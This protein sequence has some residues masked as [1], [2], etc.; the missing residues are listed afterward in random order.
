MIGAQDDGRHR[1]GTMMIHGLWAKLRGRRPWHAGGRFRLGWFST[2]N[3]K[4]GIAE[5]SKFLLDA[6]DRRRFDWTVLGSQN[7]AL[8]APDTDRV[9][10]C[11]SD[12]NGPVDP[13]LAALREERF[14]GLV[15]QFNFGFLSLADL[16]AVISCCR[17]IGT[18]LLITF[19]S[20][21]DVTIDGDVVSLGDI[22]RDLAKADRILVHSADDVARLKGFG[23]AD[24]V[25]QFPHG[26]IDG[27]AHDRAEARAALGLPPDGLVIGSYGFCLPHKGIDQ[28]IEA[29]PLL[30]AAGAPAK[31]LLVNALY[32]ASVS[33]ELLDRCRDRV[34]ALGLGD[35]VVFE[36]RFLANEDSIRTLAACDII[37][38]AYQGTQES[39]SA[40]VRMG[41]A[42]R[43]PILCSPLPIFSDVASVV[44]F[45]PGTGPEDI[46]DGVLAFLADATNR[47]ALAARQDVWLK[48]H[49]WSRVS[50]QLQRMLTA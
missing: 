48:D 24:N 3:A 16:A 7:D 10:R 49:S 20:T 44:R 19:H 25:V 8:L 4:C 30:R 47:E 1:V 26:Y 40:A 18:K 32:P 2:W 22:A 11:W 14:D 43:R 36:N 12:R 29:A 27:P 13:L 9:L 17:S 45:L 31:L 15:I 38:Y 21:A 46:R 34:A 33:R 35:D 39:S 42:A 23:V 28:L 41:I 50:V 5:Y 37:V 6:F